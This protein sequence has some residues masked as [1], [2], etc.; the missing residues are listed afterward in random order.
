MKC[1]ESIQT[2]CRSSE[3]TLDKSRESTVQV[4]FSWRLDSPLCTPLWNFHCLGS[5]GCEVVENW[6]GCQLSHF[7]VTALIRQR[8]FSKAG[9]AWIFPG[10]L[11]LSYRFQSIPYWFWVLQRFSWE[12]WWR[13]VHL[14]SWVSSCYRLKWRALAVTMESSGFD[15]KAPV[16]RNEK[17][18]LHLY[19]YSNLVFWRGLCLLRLGFR[20]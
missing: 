11:Q 15:E 3:V 17:L 18:F 6:T 10:G 5:S 20:W 7:L 9:Q 19:W 13:K 8:C 16:L 1:L 4:R 12:S 2:R 14:D